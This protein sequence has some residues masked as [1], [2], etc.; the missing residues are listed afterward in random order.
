[1]SGPLISVV[2]PTY[3]GSRYLPAALDSVLAQTCP[4]WELIVVDDGS[5]D[6][7]PQIISRYTALDARIRS[8]RHTQNRK[9]PA[10][11]NSGFAAARGQFFSWISDDNLYRPQALARMV[12]TLQAHPE[13]AVVYSDMAFID[14]T[15]A[16][17]GQMFHAPPPQALAYKAS[18][19]LCFMYRRAVQEKLGGYDEG[20]FLA[21]DYDFWLRA[22]VFFRLMPLNEDLYLY[23]VHGGSL[24]SARRR[25]VLQARERTVLKNLPHL[26]WATRRDRAEAY[27]SLSGIV[28]EMGSPR[29]G[30][31]VARAFVQHPLLVIARLLGRP[32][33]RALQGV[34]ER[35]STS[36]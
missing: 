29:A 11:L 31:Y 17:T 27:L 5:T 19:G 16:L 21:E 12:E 26:N 7:T 8:I 2:L 36:S 23:R 25:E 30:L 9:L 24:T 20:L 34:Q 35:P 6:K 10:A 1:M 4:D 33:R 32:L 14:E 15:G 3:N 28:R 22:S 13:A 18:V